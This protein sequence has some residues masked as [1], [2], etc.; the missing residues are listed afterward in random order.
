MTALIT[1]NGLDLSSIG[2]YIAFAPEVFGGPMMSNPSL[3]IL[4][5]A[6]S[7]QA[8]PSKMAPRVLTLTGSIDPSARTVAA[9][10]AAVQQAKDVFYAGNLTL[11]TTDTAGTVRQIGCRVRSFDAK[12][13][14]D[15]QHWQSA[16]V[17]DV[18]VKVLCDDPTWRDVQ[19]YYVGCPT[20]ATRY[21]LPL[22][23]APT[24][25][26]INV[27]GAATNPIVTYRNA[28]GDIVWQ[29]TFTITLAATNDWLKIDT[30][31]GRLTKSLSGTVTS[32]Y[33]V[34]TSGQTDFPRPFD[35][36]DGDV[37][38]TQ[39]PTLEISSGS[40]ESLFWKR[41]L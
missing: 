26:I 8:P 36:Q 19:P 12:P 2:M 6:G 22:G 37:T 21:A 35:P 4:G 20:A 41:W 10:Q 29:L 18:T 33:D 7:L 15:K 40:M 23:T 24:N 28:A 9:L 1:V 16:Q 34:L 31:K 14:L 39:W 17:A 27:M 30:A 13:R 3:D 38:T 25:A 32:A 5:R 11:A